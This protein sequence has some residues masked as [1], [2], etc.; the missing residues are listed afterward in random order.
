MNPFIPFIKQY[1][2]AILDGALA[3]E[4]ERRGADLNDP[5]WSSKI[6]LENPA[7]IQEVHFDYLHAGADVITTTSYQTTFEGLAK[8]GIGRP[9]A[10]VIFEK[11]VALA[12]QVR[13]SFWAK[14]ANRAGRMRPLVAISI[15]PFGASLAD[16]SEYRGD[17][18]L[19]K[20]E[21]MTFHQQRFDVLAKAGGDIFAFETIP[22]LLEAEALVA[23]LQTWP[24]KQAWLSFSCRNEAA[25][26]FG[27]PIEAC[28]RLA[29]DAPQI[30]AVGVNCTAPEYI[31]G[32]LKRC[33]HLAKKPLL[34][35][36]NSGEKWDARNHCWTGESRSKELPLRAGEW[37]KMGARILGGCCRTTPGDVAALAGLRRKLC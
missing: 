3:T 11:S 17:Y 18:G 12:C 1:G 24:E 7:L 25:T 33:T 16:G 35:Y 23:V 28:I 27:D 8:R 22:S 9:E 37:M 14:P 32:L 26:N 10:E 19:T 30:A 15:G 31:G 36:P 34:A 13:D 4:L 5:L 29:N 2:V 21:L 6:L 20:S